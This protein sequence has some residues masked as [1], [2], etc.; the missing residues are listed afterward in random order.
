MTAPG[1]K[2]QLWRFSALALFYGGPLLLLGLSIANL[3]QASS[4]RDIAARQ[5]AT[6]SRIEAQVAKHRFHGLSPRDAALLYLASTSASLARSEIQD[7]A[8]RL[9]D[10]AGGR[11][12]EVQF[13]STPEQEADGTVALQLSLEI[14]NKGLFQLLWTTESQLPLLEVTDMSARSNNNQG[15]T[16]PSNA[17]LLHVDLTIQGHFVR[18]GTG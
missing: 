11:L 6:L 12:A 18:K 17:G 8:T 9:V 5:Q 2:V 7:V 14:E 13:T 10:A 3:A 15:D 16:G 4:A 1:V